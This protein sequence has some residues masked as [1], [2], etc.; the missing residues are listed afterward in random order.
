MLSS[1]AGKVTMTAQMPWEAASHLHLL[2]DI[3]FQFH[4][5]K[6]QL[7]DQTLLGIF[8][9]DAG[10]LFDP[11]QTIRKSAPVDIQQL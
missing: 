4:K 1:E 8:Q 10:D 2:P 6:G 7:Q 5:I 11:F 9:I 3:F